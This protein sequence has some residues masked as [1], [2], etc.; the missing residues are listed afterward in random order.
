[1]FA[2]LRQVD[3][4]ANVCLFW[5]DERKFEMWV[6]QPRN[7]LTTKGMCSSVDCFWKTSIV[8]WRVVV[9]VL[10][11]NLKKTLLVRAAKFTTKPGKE[12]EQMPLAIIWQN[13]EWNSLQ[14][15]FWLLRGYYTFR[16][17]SHLN[18]VFYSTWL[19]V[20]RRLGKASFIP[21]LFQDVT[22]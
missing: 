13:N 15:T 7:L 14:Q 4:S 12:K 10:K 20:K 2:M 5:N 8:V 19:V 1:M 21:A 11:I 16:I 6:E 22:S 18:L 3:V 17:C 9:Q